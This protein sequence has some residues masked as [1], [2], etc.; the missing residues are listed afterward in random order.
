MV[1]Y[2]IL[3]NSG[4]LQGLVVDS[5]LQSHCQGRITK[6]YLKHAVQRAEYLVLAFSKNR[7]IL[8]FA[9]LDVHPVSVYVKLICSSQRQGRALMQHVAAFAQLLG[10]RGIELEAVQGAKGFYRRIGFTSVGKVAGAGRDTHMQK[11]LTSLASA[12]SAPSALRQLAGQ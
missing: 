9:A 5:Q 11:Q 2:T 3:P 7:H 8:G 4:P 6:A 1:L 10:K 12:G